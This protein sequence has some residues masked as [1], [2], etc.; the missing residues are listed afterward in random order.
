MLLFNVLRLC[1][2]DILGFSIFSSSVII[3]QFMSSAVGFFEKKLQ[4]MY[5]QWD[6]D[7]PSCSCNRVECK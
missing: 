5:Y 2:T 3:F 1:V 7:K 6:I 4:T